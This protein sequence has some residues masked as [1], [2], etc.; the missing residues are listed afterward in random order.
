[1]RRKRGAAIGVVLV[2]VA[3]GACGTSTSSEVNQ[4]VGDAGHVAHAVTQLSENAMRSWCPAAVADNG[5][6]LTQTQARG[7]LR[8][9]WNGWLG[10][11][12]R[13]GYDPNKVGEGK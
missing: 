9:V 1:M 10:E 5:R 8:R 2:T 12:K 11:L 6:R 7:C 4:A 3:L 13:N